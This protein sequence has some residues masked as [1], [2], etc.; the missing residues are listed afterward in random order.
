MK[1][2]SAGQGS[3]FVSAVLPLVGTPGGQQAVPLTKRHDMLPAITTRTGGMVATDWA[4]VIQTGIGAAAA[5]GGDFVGAWMQGR[6]AAGSPAVPSLCL[7]GCLA[8]K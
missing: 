5:L 3:G 6:G 2:P 8:S 4:P 7:A 1:I